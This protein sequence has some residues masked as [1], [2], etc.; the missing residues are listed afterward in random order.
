MLF[1]DTTGTLLSYVS[2]PSGIP[3]VEEFLARAAIADDDPSV[4]V[5]KFDRRSGRYATLDVFEQRQLRNRDDVSQID[6]AGRRLLPTLRQA[7]RTIRQYP[8][9]DRDADRQFADAATDNGRRGLSYQVAKLLIRCYRLIHYGIAKL[10]T[11]RSQRRQPVDLSGGTILLSNAA[12][13]TASRAGSLDPAQ[14]RAFICHDL[15]PLLYPHY[16][17]NKDHAERFATSVRN[18]M[19]HPTTALCTSETSSAMMRDYARGAS[20]EPARIRRIRLPSTLYE[21]AGHHQSPPASPA[22]EPFV[23][24]CSTIEVRKNHLLLARIWQRA[25]DDGVTLP[26]LLC[27]GKWGWGVQELTD[28]LLAH[29]A[30][31]SRITFTGPASDAELIG[32]YRTA[33][34]GVVPSRVEGWGYG[35][36]ECLDFGVP[37]IVSTAPALREATCGLMPAIDPD[38]ENG[39]Y[40]EIRR[41]SESHDLRASYRQKIAERYQ[42]TSTAASWAQVKAALLND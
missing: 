16:A 6:A 36:S 12:A 17:M 2:P 26:K 22:T 42:P 21:K 24:Y 32:Y 40:A 35:A 20:L 33:L 19:R 4:L 18:I 28:Y 1:V 10:V 9:I 31:S 41:L 14:E 37:V 15:I 34:F 39:W 11:P 8:T 27:V 7:F 25:I 30:L 29:P 3:R 23:L 38:D 13:M 5:V